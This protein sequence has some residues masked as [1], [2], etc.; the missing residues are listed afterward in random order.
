MARTNSHGKLSNKKIVKT[1]EIFLDKDND[2]AS[3]RLGK[4]IESK[5]YEKDGF[6]FSEDSKGRIIEIQIL[7]LSTLAKNLKK[8][9]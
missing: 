7:N 1:P 6:L 5:S 4:G 8:S 2:F 9:A 3:I